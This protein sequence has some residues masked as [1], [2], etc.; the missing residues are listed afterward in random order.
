MR[1][2]CQQDN[3]RLEYKSRQENMYNRLTFG[4]KHENIEMKMSGIVEV[5]YAEKEN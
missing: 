2:K 1:Q 3:M 5:S 4:E